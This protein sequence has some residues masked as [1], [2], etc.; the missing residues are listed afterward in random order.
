[1]A[2]REARLAISEAASASSEASLSITEARLAKREADPD[3]RKAAFAS[4][5]YQSP[6]VDGPF[7]PSPDRGIVVAEPGAVLC[8]RTTDTPWKRP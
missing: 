1:E 4:V 2:K 3:R 8:G 5:P 7:T 6:L